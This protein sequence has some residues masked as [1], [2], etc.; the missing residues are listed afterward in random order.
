MKVNNNVK[1]QVVF[2][3]RLSYDSSLILQ[4]LQKTTNNT[5]CVGFVVLYVGARDLKFY[6][7]LRFGELVAR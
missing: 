6:F 3:D 1:M 4:L 2:D 5:A 7:V